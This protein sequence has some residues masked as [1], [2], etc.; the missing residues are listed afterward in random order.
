MAQTALDPASLRDEGAGMNFDPTTLSPSDVYRLL[1]NLITPRPIAWISTV[2]PSGVVNLA[3][4]SFFNGVGA[5]PPTVVFSAVNHRDG[6]KKDTV[7]NIEANGEFV[8]NVAS[9]DLR[10]ALN[11]TAADLPYDDSELERAGLT[12]VPS[13]RVRPARVAQAKA[14][15][16]CVL[17]QIVRVGDGP[18]A[19]NLVIGRVVLVHVVDAALDG[20]GRVDQRQLD[21]IGRMGGDAYARTTDLFSLPRP[22]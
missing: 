3:P 7:V 21:T 22:R 19:A 13:A 10:E 9:F 20:Q 15:L 18:L 4:F 17:H 5:S 16:E 12:P 1:I 2:S 14:H 11:A 6:R 8:V